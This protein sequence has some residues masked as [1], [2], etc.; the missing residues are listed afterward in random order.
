MNIMF[1]DF[2]F[3]ENKFKY[4]IGITEFTHLNKFSI[5]QSPLIDVGA[6]LLDNWHN[7]EVILKLGVR[8]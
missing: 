6:F 7:I 8:N 4:R 2:I 5:I 1:R 3:F